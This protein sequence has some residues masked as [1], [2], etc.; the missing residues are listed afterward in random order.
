[1][2]LSLGLSG[3]YD[4]RLTV[5]DAIEPESLIA[6][7][8]SRAHL[9]YGLSDREVLVCRSDGSGIAV[10]SESGTITRVETW[11]MPVRGSIPYGTHGRLAW[12]FPDAGRLLHRDLP[13]N[14]YA[15]VVGRK[16]F[17]LLHRRHTKLVHCHSLLSGV[18]NFSPVDAEAPDFD[19]FPR[20]RDAPV[21]QV[22]LEPGDVLYIPSLWWHQACP[23]SVS[24]GI[25][26][27][28]VRGPMLA[29][30]RAAEMVMRAFKLRL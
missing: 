21:V 11:P 26:M 8:H 23:L 14:L 4:D 27:W 22:E 24:M 19:R 16:R 20:F 18:P 6:R 2:G 7:G 29:A 1:V 15:Q 13:E 3:R 25:N 10:L 17:T 30:V 9:V 12:H 28:W 5:S